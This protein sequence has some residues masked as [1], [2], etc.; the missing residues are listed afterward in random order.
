MAFIIG[1][2]LDDRLKSSNDSFDVINGLGGSDTVDY[3]DAMAAVNVSLALTG[4]Q[5]TGDLVLIC[6]FRLKILLEVSFPIR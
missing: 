3:F 1:T 2:S 4:A 6:S 5:N